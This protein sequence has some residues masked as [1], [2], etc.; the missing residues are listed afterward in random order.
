MFG[1][2]GHAAELGYKVIFIFC[3]VI[4]ECFPNRVV[5]CYG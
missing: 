4:K 1:E 3:V 2:G 5:Q